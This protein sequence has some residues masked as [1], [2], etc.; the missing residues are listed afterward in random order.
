LAKTLLKDANECLAAALTL[1]VM[2]G[3][4]TADEVKNAQKPGYAGV[5]DLLNEKY[6]AMVILEGK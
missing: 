6:K 2:K 1:L 4:L 3:V 5:W